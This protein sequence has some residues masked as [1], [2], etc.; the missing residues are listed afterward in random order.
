M[1]TLPKTS[2][3]VEKAFNQLRNDPEKFYEY[4]QKIPLSTIETLYKK[5][6]LQA[7]VLSAMLEAFAEFGINDSESIK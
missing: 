6:E 1:S 7:E 4:L 5:S 3:G 2:A